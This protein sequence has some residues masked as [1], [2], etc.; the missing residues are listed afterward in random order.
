MNQLQLHTAGALIR[1]TSPFSDLAVNICDTP[2]SVGIRDKWVKPLYFGLRDK[3]TLR[4]VSENISEIDQ[5]LI[6]TLLG[7]FDWRSRTVGAHLAAI[8]RRDEFQEEIG[9]L[10]LRSDV[11]YAAYGYCVAIATFNNK[12]GIEYL[13]EYLRYYLTRP[14]LV[15]DQTDVMTTLV[16]LDKE[17]GTEFAATC[18]EQWASYHQ[19]H[20]EFDLSKS[21]ERF[22]SYL[23]LVRSFGA[24]REG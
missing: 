13:L 22:R 4:F 6:S 15:F 8:T 21:V 14:D 11:C 2:L 20:E 7:Q 18:A 19:A 12:V 10:L 9:K 23:D 3:A 5:P 24:S 17:N 16:L 1:H